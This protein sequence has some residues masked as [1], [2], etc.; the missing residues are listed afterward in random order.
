MYKIGNVVKKLSLWAQSNGYGT[1][2]R[3]SDARKD[4]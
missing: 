3:K 1:L 2:D 4:A